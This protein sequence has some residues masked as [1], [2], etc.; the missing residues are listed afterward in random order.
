MAGIDNYS[1]IT[2]A[3]AKDL[4]KAGLEDLPKG[5]E[6]EVLLPRHEYPIWNGFMNAVKQTVQ[7]GTSYTRFVHLGEDSSGAWVNLY[8]P[9]TPAVEDKLVKINVPWR[10][11]TTDHSY[12]RR[13][14]MENRKPAQLVN[15]LKSRKTAKWMKI[16]EDMEEQFW[17]TPDI[18]DTKTPYGYWY[19]FPKIVV[20]DS[21]VG[22][23]K[24]SP[25]GFTDVL[26]INSST[27]KYGRWKSYAN[28]WDAGSGDLNATDR[29]IISHMFRHLKFNAPM[30][31]EEA[32]SGTF[33]LRLLAGETL[34]DTMEAMLRDQNENLGTD[35]VKYQNAVVLKGIPVDWAEELDDDTDYPLCAMNTN[36][37]YPVALSGDYFY[38]HEPMNDVSLPNV[39]TVNT[40]LTLCHA[41]TNRQRAGGVIS[42]NA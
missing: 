18:D 16:F 35:I 34:I 27:A 36:Y 30:K 17:A 24:D 7:S 31:M 19:F 26:G 14:L 22:H 4:I 10:Y 15:L 23:V 37:I 2:D 21:T 1:P 29:T 9:K 33:K 20:G 38:D 25:S 5:G 13:E 40:D 32:L 41:C 11:Y 28:R 39:Y 3:D 8:E 6:F 12:E 42:D